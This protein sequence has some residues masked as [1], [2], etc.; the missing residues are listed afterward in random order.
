MRTLYVSSLFIFVFVGCVQAQKFKRPYQ[1]ERK[2]YL[3]VGAGVVAA[4][5]GAP[6]KVTPDFLKNTR[7][8]YQFFIAPQL[9]LSPRINLGIKL[10]GVF[11]PKFYEQESSSQLQG[12]LTPYALPFLDFYLGSANR[13]RSARF[14]FGV[15]GGA[16]Y[17]GTLEARNT[18][19]DEAYGLRRENRDIF[20]TIA[21]HVGLVFGDLKIQVE[22]I[23][24]L[25]ATPAIT[26]LTLSNIIPMGRRR[27]F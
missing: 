24:T 3:E 15:G 21:P 23:I 18:I 12:K 22:H 19:T 16:T 2:G 25:P 11:R 27:Y 26:S 13:T 5:A 1:D 17:I 14:F 8:G 9:L 20:P 7:L 10:G 4:Q 6:Y